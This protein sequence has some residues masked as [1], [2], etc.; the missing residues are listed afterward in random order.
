VFPF[1]FSDPDA[2]RGLYGVLFMERINGLSFEMEERWRRTL[3]AR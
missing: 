3:K 1:L 2:L